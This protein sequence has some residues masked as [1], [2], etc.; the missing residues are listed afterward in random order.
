MAQT[1]THVVARVTGGP[2]PVSGDAVGPLRVLVVDDEDLIRQVI[3]T[4][5]RRAGFDV[6]EARDGLEALDC[7]RTAMPDLVLTD[8]DMPRCNGEELC[9]EIKRDRATAPRN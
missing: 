1:E 9:T 6:D 2:S 7:L 8:L 5:L 4:I 3:G